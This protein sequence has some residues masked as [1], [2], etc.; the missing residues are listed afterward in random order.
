[1]PGEAV[2]SEGS[3][4]G[5]G[6]GGGAAAGIQRS[7]FLFMEYLIELAFL[8]EFTCLLHALVFAGK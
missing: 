7:P 8:E 2:R 5:V 1:M 3:W 6:A 4:A